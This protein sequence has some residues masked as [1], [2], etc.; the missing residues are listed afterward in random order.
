MLIFVPGLDRAK[1]IAHIIKSYSGVQLSKSYEIV[2]MAYGYEGWNHLNRKFEEGAVPPHSAEE[3][4]QQFVES[5]LGAGISETDTSQIMSEIERTDRKGDA[6]TRDAREHR[7]DAFDRLVKLAQEGKSAEFTELA[8]ELIGRLDKTQTARVLDMVREHAPRSPEAALY[9]TRLYLSGV[10]ADTEKQ[11]LEGLFSFATSSER[12][13]VRLSAHLGLALVLSQKS[14]GNGEVKRNLD[15]AV[16]GDLPEALFTLARFH[17]YGVHGYRR[18]LKKALG[19][20]IEMYEELDAEFAALEIAR[21]LI[22]K[23]ELYP[24]DY[25][26]DPI[27]LL[28]G[29]ADD[30][31]SEAMEMLG[32]IRSATKLNEQGYELGETIT[33]DGG[34][35]PKLVRDALK[36]A[37]DLST[38]HAESLTAGLFGYTSWSRLNNAANDKRTVKGKFDEE[39]SAP[40]FVKR[41][42]LQR[43]LLCYRLSL[44]E[45]IAEIAIRLLKP[46]SR[47][48]KPS[49]RRL[50]QEASGKMFPFASDDMMGSVQPFLDQVGIKSSAGLEGMNTVRDM[51]PVNPAGWLTVLEHVGFKIRNGRTKPTLSGE[52]IGEIANASGAI[53]IYMIGAAYDPGDLSDLLVDKHM[54]TIARKSDRAFLLF[55]KPTFIVAKNDE[56]GV[57]YGGRVYHEGAWSDFVLSPGVTVDD[58]IAQRAAFTY[59]L[60]EE[61]ITRHTYEG[62]ISHAIAIEA[63]SRGDDPETVEYHVI[64]KGSGWMSLLSGDAAS[65]MQMMSKMRQAMPF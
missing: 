13:N 57:L 15:I 43:N 17:E 21:L 59:P 25:E 5:M 45:Y 36:G 6:D 26:Y 35:R 55:G 40:E 56:A 42:N 54:K 64:K 31:S 8:G 29:L 62:C 41:Q 16:N 27:E 50:E 60:N 11:S 49:L 20:Y 2:G 28:T 52:V 63:S 44:D 33:P 32:A 30:G 51:M 48:G 39:C 1:A 7:Q 24:E 46:T 3:R 47:L 10:M 4:R 38:T 58:L 23:N 34:K 53:P 19:L 37:F 65:A 22:T 18:D 14:D 61:F 9:A 12:D